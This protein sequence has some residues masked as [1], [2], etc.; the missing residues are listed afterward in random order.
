MFI[1]SFLLYSSTSRVLAAEV[2]NQELS[3]L[4]T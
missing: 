1:S 2:I 4:K 3:F